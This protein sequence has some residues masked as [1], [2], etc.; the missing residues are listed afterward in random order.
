[1]QVSPRGKR[2]DY[3]HRYEIQVEETGVRSWVYEDDI[4]P[5]GSAERNPRSE[6][7]FR[8]GMR[9][10]REHDDV[11]G[12]D[13]RLVA[14]IARA[15]LR[16]KPD[17][18]TRLERC[19]ENPSDKNKESAMLSK[20]WKK[21]TH[22]QEG[23]AWHG[24]ASSI[25]I[26]ACSGEGE[27]INLRNCTRDANKVTCPRCLSK[28]RRR[29]KR[30]MERMTKNLSRDAKM[31]CEVCGR[32]APENGHPCQFENACSCWRG[33]PCSNTKRKSHCLSISDTSLNTWFE[34]DRA[35]VELI[36]DATGDTLIEWWDG[37][38]EEAAEDGFLV[39][40]KG[41]HALH[42]SAFE[43]WESLQ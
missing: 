29:A 28:M 22:L 20:D 12:G 33:E 25:A 41:K 8:R 7:Q 42:K 21:Y 27:P 37:A 6:S 39:F 16:E 13:P 11:T 36:N 43:Y 26:V 19:V 5:A 40:G 18:Y 38:V 32:V 14:Q 15:H 35:H 23:A 30:K 24:D 9:V 17:Y 3:D 34:R 1:M 4:E 10:E 2:A 31:T